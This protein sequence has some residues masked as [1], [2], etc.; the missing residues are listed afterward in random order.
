MNKIFSII[1][2][3]LRGFFFGREHL[4][5]ICLQNNNELRSSGGFITKVLEIEVSFLKVKPKFLNVFEDF[6]GS[7]IVMPEAFGYSLGYKDGQKMEFR[8]SNLSLSDSQNFLN[9]KEIYKFNF[10]KDVREIF[11]VNYQFIENLL[12]VYGYVNVKGEKWN[13]E[14]LFR[15]LS[16]A[17]SDIDRHNLE[18]LRGRK[19]IMKGVLRSLFIKMFFRFYKI[20]DLINLV[21]LSFKNKELQ[22]FNK[23]MKEQV[24]AVYRENNLIGLKNNRYVRRKLDVI[25]D[26]SE[27]G[28]NRTYIFSWYHPG[29]YNWPL[30]GKYN[31]I[32]DFTPEE[33]FEFVSG[34]TVPKRW[35]DEMSFNVALKPKESQSVVIETFKKMEGIP[36]DYYIRYRKQS[37]LQDNFS[38]I[39][40]CPK[41]YNIDGGVDYVYKYN[42]T[43][44]S[45]LDLKVS[46]SKND[47][48]PRVIQHEIVGEDKVLIRFNEEV[49][50]MKSFELSLK[51]K[52]SSKDFKL[53]YVWKE[54]G[55]E[56]LIT[57][58]DW[59]PV[60]EEFFTIFIEG[61]QN[62][63]GVSVDPEKRVLTVVYRPKYFVGD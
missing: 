60:L 50:E 34:V 41:G 31:A 32:L 59:K 23:D 47:Y 1:F 38:E 37:G 61:V 29:E 13:S 18:D 45:D 27:S 2:K 24:G 25:T 7:N 35:Q 40:S 17:T 57:V 42:N 19:D 39:V 58:L 55:R 56:L 46:I 43:P 4:F 53:M 11:L 28:I 26:I 52:E 5:L 8:D 33:G 51:S 22:L 30:S 48:P 62:K 21:N 20:F 15:K 36:K 12:N 3:S 14:N 44:D 16:K 49:E 6:N 54:D 63:N 10:E 9:M